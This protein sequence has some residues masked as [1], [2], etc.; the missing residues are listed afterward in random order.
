[1]TITAGDS[2]CSL[3]EI[4]MFCTGSD[5]VP[6]VGFCK[7]IDVVFLGSQAILPT[8]ST[9]SLELRIP[10]CH[11]DSSSFSEMMSLGLKCGMEFGCI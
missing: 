7:K 3:E 4:L 5:S 9:C 2:T 11:N 6:P 10:T 8:A 1:M